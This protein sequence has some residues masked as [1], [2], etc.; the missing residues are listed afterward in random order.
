MKKLILSLSIP[1]VVGLTIYSC[2][3]ENPILRNGNSIA[4]GNRSVQRVGLIDEVKY[5]LDDFIII[6][7]VYDV[8]ELKK[9]PNDADEEKLNN[10]LHLIAEATKDLIK[11][12]NFNQI[13]IQMA[14]ENSNQTAYLLDL[15]TKA[16]SYYDA[17]NTKLQINNTNLKAIASFMTHSPTNP[18]PDY[19][20]TAVIEKYEPGIFIPNLDKVNNTWQPLISPNIEV[21]SLLNIDDSPLEDHVITW[22]FDALGNQ[23]EILIGEAI[24]EQ[25]ENP[26][27]LLDHASTKT[28][29]TPVVPKSSGGNCSGTKR[30]DSKEIKIKPGYRHE[31]GTSRSEFCIQAYRIKSNGTVEWVYDPSGWKKIGEV[32]KSNIG[33]NQTFQTLHAC[34]YEPYSQNRF[35]WNT[36]E[37][38]WNR[39]P[40]D[41]GSASYAGKT[42]YL[43]ERMRYDGD[44][45][46]WIPS[47]LK[48]HATPFE[49]YGWETK[50]NFY[51]WK[52]DYWV[53]VVPN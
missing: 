16:K 1:A 5:I 29:N 32:H 13:I 46:A 50:V 36:Y 2:K 34:N 21:N 7:N 44:W 45:Y 39:S 30:F 43:G 26:I 41:L 10:Q 28:K 18:N 42:I 40:K 53:Y 47:T 37:R 9:N 31:T 48:D 6:P 24:S 22:Y 15:E 51:S 23:H 38:D 49:W 27:F 17:I 20:E 12:P 11:D 4:E 19:P 25:I 35:F 8:E 33:T 3:K 52:S 14:Q